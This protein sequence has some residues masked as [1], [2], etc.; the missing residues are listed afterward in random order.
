MY[1]DL[2]LFLVPLFWYLLDE[3]GV[4]NLDVDLVGV[5]KKFTFCFFGVVVLIN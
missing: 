3:N 2:S 5:Y 1:S 4:P